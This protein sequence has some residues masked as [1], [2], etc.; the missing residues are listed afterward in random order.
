MRPAGWVVLVLLAQTAS[1]E[2]IYPYRYRTASG[3][4]IYANAPIESATRWIIIRR[5]RNRPQAPVMP[6]AYPKA[7]ATAAATPTSYDG[8]IRDVADRHGVEYALVK[9]VIKAESD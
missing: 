7:S 5:V 9:A 4:T 1:A 2:V 8:P 3:A 6:V